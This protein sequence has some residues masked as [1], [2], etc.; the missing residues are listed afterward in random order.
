MY[1]MKYRLPWL[2]LAG[3]AIVALAGGCRSG[4]APAEDISVTGARGAAKRDK[5]ASSP[6]AHAHYATGV[7]HE[8]NGEIDLALEAFRRAL[9]EDPASE[10]LVLQV[11]HR[12]LLNKRP[13]QALEILRTAAARKTA[14]GEIHA[15]LGSVYLLLGRGDEA[16]LANQTAVKQSPLHL[17]AYQNLLMNLLQAKRAEEALQLLDSAAAV[18]GADADFLIG[19]A[20]LYQNYL[21]QFPT[22]REA[23]DSRTKAVLRRAIEL[24]PS[25]PESRL[26][27]A[28]GLY[29][30]GES[31]AA[32]QIYL[33]LL[34][35]IADLPL[36]RDSIRS[37]LVEIFLRSDDRSRA[38]Q[39]LENVLRDDPSNPQAY[40]LLGSI[41][42]E[43][44]H[45][46]EAAEYLRKTLMFAPAFEQAYYDLAA[47]QLAGDDAPGA[48]GTL[49][50]AEGRFA[51]TF[52]SAYLSALAEVR[53]KNFAEAI[54]HFTQAEIVAK[55][56]DPRRLGAEFY[57]EAGVAF[58][59]KGDREEAVQYFEKALA[60]KS[61]FPEAQ[62]YLGYMWA[63][64]G[65]NLERAKDL[66][67]KALKVEPES[68][69]YLDSM[70]WVLFKL[71]QPKAALDY[72][73]QAIQHTEEPDA[74]LYDH[75]GDIYAALNETGKALEAWRQSL[76]VE[77][78]PEVRKKLPTGT[79]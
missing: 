20:D 18:P 71:N 64:R 48:L 55:A 23:V 3:I 22:Q 53:T 7:L 50:R 41:A 8:M 21:L 29:R 26:R 6:R 51:P 12:F 25:Q 2:S 79:P 69:A 65:E 58:E 17:P 52:L 19:L 68:A 28:D 46:K 67:E 54:K 59:R 45:W 75:L 73:L 42:Y 36:V 15:R 78:N 24:K 62:N 77:D 76:A 27:L 56:S 9:S 37:K 60:L 74:T 32:S 35:Q 16:L 31:E 72:L 47:A 57:F 11:S 40:Y 34:D 70:G 63:E 30:L 13:E 1:R 38:R 10:A 14:S 5:A 61:E 4:R 43:D 66:I 44:K 49:R 39:Q 33:P